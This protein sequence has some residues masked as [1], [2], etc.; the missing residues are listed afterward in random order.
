MEEQGNADLKEAPACTRPRQTTGECEGGAPQGAQLAGWPSG[1][2]HC[3]VAESLWV[4]FPLRA[5]S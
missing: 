1:S 4:R 5:Q 2:E 3:S